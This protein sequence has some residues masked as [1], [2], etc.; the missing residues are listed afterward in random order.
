MAAK[1]SNGKTTLQEPEA[2]CRLAEN[3]KNILSKTPNTKRGREDWAAL[4][5]PDQVV[6]RV[7]PR[8]E[9]EEGG[10]TGRPS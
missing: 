5:W 10:D 1:S 7:T 4:P 6:E 3:M 2:P 8:G 9:E